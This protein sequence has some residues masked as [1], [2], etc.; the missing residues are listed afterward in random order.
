MDP[1][2]ITR[3]NSE[4][5]RINITFMQRKIIKIV[6]VHIQK[7]VIIGTVFIIIIITRF[8]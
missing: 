3:M 4:E 1:R 6:T 8:P 5:W 7:F 2:I